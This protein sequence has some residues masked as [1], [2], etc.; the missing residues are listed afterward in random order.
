[1]VKIPKGYGT[2]FP[3]IFAQNADKYISFLKDALGAEEIG[4]TKAPDGTVANAR[5]RLGTT[6]FM[7]SE[8]GEGYGPTSSAFYVYVENADSAFQKAVA[9]GAEPI[10]APMDM[11]YGDRQGGVRDSSGNIWWI[12]QRLVDEPYDA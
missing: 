4:V 9:K 10:H 3:Y 12:S 11:H 7:V 1:M 5:I 2:M 6:T 8:A